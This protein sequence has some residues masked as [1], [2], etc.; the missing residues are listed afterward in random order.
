MGKKAHNRAF[1]KRKGEN[2]FNRTKALKA[3]PLVILVLAA[4]FLVFCIHLSYEIEKRFSGRRWSV[5]SKLYSDTTLLFPGQKIS[6]KLLE[7][8]LER[9]GYRKVNQAVGQKGQMRLSQ[10][11]LEVFLKDLQVP[12]ASRQG[13]PLKVVFAGDV[14]LSIS[15]LRTDKAIPLIE[16]EP[17]LLMHFFG[18]ERELRRLVAFTEIP[19]HVI[20]AVLAAEDSRFYEHV[21]VDFLGILRA[22]YVNLRHGQIRQGGSTITQQL[23]KSYFLNPDRSFS[24]KVKEIFLAL[25]MEL[26]YQKNEIIEIYL[27][28]IYLGQQGSVSVS[29]IGEASYFYFGKSA[30]E[31]T[32]DEGAVI[33]GLIR[34]PNLYSPY[35]DKVR[36]TLRRNDVLGAMK[37]LNWISNDEMLE[38]V[39]TPVLLSGYEAYRRQAPYFVDYVSSQLATLYPIGDLST[40]GLSIY[41]TLDTEVQRAA[42]KALA[43]GLERLT[44]TQSPHLLGRK[45]QGAVLVMQPKTGYILAMVGGRDYGESQF[46][47]LTQAKRQPGSALKPF[48]FLSGLDRFTPATLLSNENKTYDVEGKPWR[49]RNYSTVAEREVTMRTA[50]AKS[51]NLAAV[52]LAVKVGLEQVVQT[53]QSFGFSSPVKPFPSLA[54][55]SYEVVPL[56]LARAYCAFVASGTLPQPLSVKDVM[57]EE[58]RVLE[59]RYVTVEKVTTPAKAFIIT[60]ML[61]SAVENGTAR[62]L[63]SMGIE[64][65]VAGKTGTTN[66]LRDA[67]F[68]GYTPDLLALVWVGY[69]HGAPLTGPGSEVALPIWAELMNGARQHL[70]GEEFSIPPGVI[71]KE[72]CLESGQLASS[73]GC[74][75]KENE[76]FLEDN[77]PKELCR[78]HG[79]RNPL[80]R[81]LKGFKALFGDP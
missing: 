39:S 81:I 5:P 67:W 53:V 6:R 32:L 59:Q 15:E 19:T 69:D 41:T 43:K 57:G 75:Q 63:R 20:Q 65:P 79:D 10:N 60:S 3:L 66:D 40:L 64:F 21:G 30:A 23:A 56:E 24:R 13:F 52:D 8:K 45:P 51:I 16:V 49:P 54:L 71:R 26:S 25:I 50:L 17:E 58:G 48:V 37:R 35:I 55:G 72:I 12:H 9:L 46:N 29:G 62:A 33:A 42:E 47:R 28:E 31:L 70:S 61:Q 74:F 18:R 34:A 38:A 68:V 44:R 78:I 1:L 7:Q 11:S 73:S 80:D 76:F 77:V 2:P 14:I 36:C 22:L 4:C 27:N